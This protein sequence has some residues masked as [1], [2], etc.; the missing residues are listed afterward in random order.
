MA[1]D[2][3]KMKAGAQEASIKKAETKARKRIWKRFGPDSERLMKAIDSLTTNV[4]RIVEGN[5]AYV[6]FSGAMHLVDNFEDCLP[7][8]EPVLKVLEKHN[9]PSIRYAASTRHRVGKH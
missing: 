6:K 3:R 8:V 2:P 7:V 9:D 4:R 1:S 5:S